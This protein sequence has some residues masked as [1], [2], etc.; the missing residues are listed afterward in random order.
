MSKKE[1]NAKEMYRE[2]HDNLEESYTLCCVD[3]QSEVSPKTVS[4]CIKEKNAYELYDNHYFFE[5]RRGSA[6]EHL[7][8][9]IS[10]S[11]YPESL[12][13]QFKY[14]DQYYQLIE[15][16][17]DRDCSQPEKELFTHT[18]C[19]V[20]IELHSNY[21]CWLPLWETRSLYLE[22]SAL[23]GLLAVLCLNPAKVKQE[24]LRQGIACDGRWPNIRSREGKEIVGYKDF[25]T[26]LIEC[27]NY[28]L[29]SF[30][31]TIDME[32]LWDAQ[33][34]TKDMTIPK[35]TAC[36]MYNSWNGGGS[37]AIA[38]TLRDVTI[39]ELK[40]RSA[41]YLDCPMVCVDERHC[42]TGYSSD[43]VYGEHQAQQPALV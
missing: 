34:E 6:I 30:F 14:S 3:G 7:D 25:I 37:C 42:E 27:P 18:T 36:F 41:R 15:E 19:H 20:R 13:K 39:N 26:N 12:V 23:K 28:G 10:V 9:L 8:S 16:I 11:G 38:H 31:G 43:Q 35:D 21:D 32:A 29:W 24:A 33:F 2:L 17:E 40:Q 4:T 5:Q 1:F 22:D